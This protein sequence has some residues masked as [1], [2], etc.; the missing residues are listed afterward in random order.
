MQ[1][2]DEDLYVMIRVWYVHRVAIAMSEKLHLNS[3]S[4]ASRKNLHDLIWG[5]EF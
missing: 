5:I 2:W 1:Q 4:T 3:F